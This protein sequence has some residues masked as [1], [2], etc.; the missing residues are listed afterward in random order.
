MMSF[1]IKIAITIK[2]SYLDINFIIAI[3]SA[4]ITT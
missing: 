2:C 4:I 1:I 3:I